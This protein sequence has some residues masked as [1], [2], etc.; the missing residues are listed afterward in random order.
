MPRVNRPG[1]GT[2]KT[3]SFLL[4][5]EAVRWE[6]HPSWGYSGHTLVRLPSQHGPYVS[7]PQHQGPSWE[8]IGHPAPTRLEKPLRSNGSVKQAQ[9]ASGKRT[10]QPSMS[11][12]V[13]HCASLPLGQVIFSSEQRTLVGVGGTGWEPPIS[14]VIFFPMLDKERPA[15]Q[16]ITAPRTLGAT[17]NP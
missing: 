9:R 8:A 15:D 2:L 13:C 7:L 5:L 17:V 10:L 3:A 6:Y 14:I 16:E 4:P 11:I 12:G 1:L